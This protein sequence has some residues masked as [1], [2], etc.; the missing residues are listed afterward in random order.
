VLPV[1]F[2]LAILFR[3]DSI[4]KYDRVKNDFSFNV[5]KLTHSTAQLTVVLKNSLQV[6][7]CLVYISSNS[8][9]V[10]LGKVDHQGSHSFEIPVDQEN[11]I[12]KLY[13]AI[14]KKEIMRTELTVNNN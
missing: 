8:K 2:V 13:D 10:L 9:D 4:S 3:L 14:H 6:P 11:V 12:V 5:K 1:I 7:S